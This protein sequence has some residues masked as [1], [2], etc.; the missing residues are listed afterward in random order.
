MTR[1]GI[2]GSDLHARRH[3]DQLADMASAIGYHD[4]MRPDEQVVMGHEFSGRVLEYGPATRS[5]W[6][7][8]RRWCRCR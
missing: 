5:A 1:A 2:C 7:P 3:A 8:G 6:A 4:V